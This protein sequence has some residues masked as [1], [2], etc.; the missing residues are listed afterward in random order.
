MFKRTMIRITSTVLLL[1]T[2][3][4]GPGVCLA[5]G[6]V[7]DKI[8]HPYVQPHEQELEFRA[9]FQNQ[10]ASVANN[11]RLYQM[12]YGRSLGDRWFAELYLV[13]KTSDEQNLDVEAYE[14]EAKWQMTEQGEFWA[15]FGMLFELEREANKDVWGLSSAILA[16]KEWGRWSGT[17]NFY[18]SSEWGPEIRDELETKLNL[19][20]RYRYSRAF[21]PAVEFYSGQN[22]LA[23]GP[24]FMGQIKISSGRTLEWEA[25]VIFGLDKKSPDETLRLLAAFEF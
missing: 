16:E 14:L 10:Q 7:I 21:E 12:A 5:D 11:I 4:A 19:Q 1:G 24:A 23:L 2:F 13:G 17:A 22:T 8:Y 9:L 3:I 15:D 6:V 25:G 18:L 20:A